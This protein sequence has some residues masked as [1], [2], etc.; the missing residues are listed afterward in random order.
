VRAD[1]LL[2]G[3]RLPPWPAAADPGQLLPTPAA[4]VKMANTFAVV[5]KLLSINPHVQ[6]DAWEIVPGWTPAAHAINH[7]SEA[8]SRLVERDESEI[9][10]ENRHLLSRCSHAGLGFVAPRVLDRQ[11]SNV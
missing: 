1:R 4:C 7:L 11:G 3:A 8:G 5:T 10:G 9:L 6:Y 2:S